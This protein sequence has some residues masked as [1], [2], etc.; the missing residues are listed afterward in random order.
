MS[1]VLFS[2]I[3]AE[4]FRQQRNTQLALNTARSNVNRQPRKLIFGIIKLCP[5]YAMFQTYPMY[6]C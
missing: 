4:L 2:L 1:A 6:D 5:N 3:E